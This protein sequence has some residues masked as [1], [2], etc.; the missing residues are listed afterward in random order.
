MIRALKAAFFL[1]YPIAGLGAVPIN[2]IGVACFG[3]L[4][5]RN[6]GFWF[7]GAGLETAYLATLATNWRFQRWV[8]A[9]ASFEESGDVEAKR[10]ALL[11]QL[12][13]PDRLAMERLS[14]RC[15]R[16]V[17]LWRAHDEVVVQSNLG[18][19]RD[20]QWVYLK[21][22]LAKRH[23]L[24]SEGDADGRALANDIQALE[25]ELA[26]ARLST[27]ARESKRATLDLLKRRAVN[28][29]R[30]RQTLDEIGS[31]LARVEQ[32]VALVLENTTLEGKPQ[33]V[34]ADLNLASQLLDGSYFG[35]S[36]DDIAAVDAV[37]RVTHRERVSE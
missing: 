4:G 35:S 9:Q 33:A 8:N 22:L 20:L 11:K 19:L 5:F 17:S 26:E 23:L 32:Q 25:R 1:R 13:P 21:L 31:D 7:A 37:Y 3:L 12:A 18:A 10:L 24:G 29:V 27:A 6:H 36:A 14:G 15:D 28:I 34:S 16:I 2:L 30:R